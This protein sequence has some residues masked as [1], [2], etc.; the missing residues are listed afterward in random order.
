MAAFCGFKPHLKFTAIISQSVSDWT[1]DFLITKIQKSAKKVKKVFKLPKNF[2][3][4]VSAQAIEAETPQPP[5]SGGE[6]LERKARFLRVLP[7]KCA[8]NLEP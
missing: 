7:Q 1:L 2:R 3:L 6:E 4:A 8:R 5:Y